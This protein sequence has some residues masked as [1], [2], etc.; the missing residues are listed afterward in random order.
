M[1]ASTFRFMALT[2]IIAGSLVGGCGDPPADTD[3]NEAVETVQSG[4]TANQRLA[5][6]NQDPRVV[7]GLVSAQIC[8]GADI[9]FR[10]TFG[11]NGRTC[12]TCHPANHNFTIDDTFVQN[13]HNTNPNDPLFVFERNPNIAHLEDSGVLIGLGSILENVDGF[14][15]DPTQKFIFR[16][17]PHT[18]S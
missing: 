10:E 7:A 16:S 2:P 5:A 15:P 1:R 11:G 9:F 18:L 14:T 8:A 12:G 13:L 6:C 17:V 3:T 4:L